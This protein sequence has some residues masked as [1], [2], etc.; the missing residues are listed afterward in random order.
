MKSDLKMKAKEMKSVYENTFRKLASF[1]RV[2]IIAG[3][4]LLPE[5]EIDPNTNLLV[6]KNGKFFNASFGRGL[7]S[8][9]V[10]FY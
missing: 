6:I 10:V 8:R 4:I 9:F 5:P 1:Y 2:T 7:C 3:S